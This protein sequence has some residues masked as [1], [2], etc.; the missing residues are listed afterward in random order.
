MQ[1]RK[2]IFVKNNKHICYQSLIRQDDFP[3]KA[4]AGLRAIDIDA[5]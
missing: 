4:L 2:R 3:E 5:A 1:S